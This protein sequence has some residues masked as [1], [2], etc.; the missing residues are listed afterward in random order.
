MTSISNQSSSVIVAT[1][2]FSKIESIVDVGGE[3]GMLLAT[4]LKANPHLKGILFDLPEVIERTRNSECLM[5]EISSG[6]CQ[7]VPGNFFEAVPEGADAYL[8]KNII[9]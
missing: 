4:I 9:Y 2:D 1:Y 3:N 6:Q 5:T 8:M 7:L